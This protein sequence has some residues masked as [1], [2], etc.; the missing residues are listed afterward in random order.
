[1]SVP[2][3]PK[4]LTRR[5]RH[6]PPTRCLRQR[7]GE[8]DVVDAGA[9]RRRVE[10]DLVGDRAGDPVAGERRR[11]RHV[12]RGDRHVVLRGRV[13]GGA[14]L[15][16]QRPRVG[17]RDEVRAGG[18]Q[19]QLAFRGV[20]VEADAEPRP[21]AHQRGDAADRDEPCDQAMQA[22]GADVEEGRSRDRHPCTC[23]RPNRSGHR[24]RRLIRFDVAV[25]REVPADRLARPCP[26]GRAGLAEQAEAVRLRAFSMA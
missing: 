16:E 7:H 4:P 21:V 11:R 20:A 5:R 12:E 24:H 10:P 15:Q 25:E 23:R 22:V 26:R 3:S 13:A 17:D 2:S 6:V 18:R 19:E 14:S 9:D 8:Q 1:M